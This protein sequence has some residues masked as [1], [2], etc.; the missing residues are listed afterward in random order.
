MFTSGDTG[1]GAE[2][3]EDM[4]EV[5]AT[6]AGAMEGHVVATAMAEGSMGKE[7]VEVD[8]AVEEPMVGLGVCPCLSKSKAGSKF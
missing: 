8:M 2:E 5:K 7:A 1:A 4:D 6:S 3:V